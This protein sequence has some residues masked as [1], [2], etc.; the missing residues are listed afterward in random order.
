MPFAPCSSLV[1]SVGVAAA[2]FSPAISPMDEAP[3]TW[4]ELGPNWVLSRRRAVLAALLG[5]WLA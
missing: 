4:T 2:A 1:D 5:M 3:V